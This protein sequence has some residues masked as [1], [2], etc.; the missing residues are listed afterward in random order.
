MCAAPSFTICATAAASRHESEKRFDGDAAGLIRTPIVS[1]DYRRLIVIAGS[2]LCAPLLLGGC[3]SLIAGV[4][5]D[6]LTAAIL[7]QDDPEL[8]SSGVPAYMLLLD[9]MISQSPDNA[10]LLSAGAQLYSLYGSS[11]AEDPE[12]ARVLT[13]KARR[14]GA[15]AIC[16]SDESMCGADQLPYDT[17]VSQL[18]EFNNKNVDYL[19]A[20]AISW[21]S[22]LDATSEDWSAVAELPWVEAALEQVLEVDE[23]YDNGTLQSYLGILKSLRPPAL[24]GKPEEAQAHFERALVISAEQ[25]LAIKLE[26]A[27]RYAR[28]MFEQ[29]LHDRLLNEVL[30]APANAPG[31]T[32]FNMLAKQEAAELLA[33]SADYF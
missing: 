4:A 27:R 20:F 8:V 13:G 19:Y 29:E 17:F 16:L 6:T 14:Y 30:A 28:M 3:A 9:G 5:A 25:N 23:A 1:G 18:S 2:V 7:N 15:R 26:Y 10:S 11:F 33:T 21:L 12:R 24:G 31:L 22:N 32:L